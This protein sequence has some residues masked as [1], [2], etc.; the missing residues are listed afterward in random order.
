M[1]HPSAG[2]GAAPSASSKETNHPTWQ[3]LKRWFVTTETE[4]SFVKSLTFIGFL[5]TLIAAYFQYLSAYQEKVTARAKEDLAAAT[6]AF[7]E[8]ANALSIPLSLQE[9]LVFAFYDA[10]NNK[11]DVDDNAYV[12]KRAR[13]IAERYEDAYT[14]LRENINL[15]ARKVEIYLDWPS[16]LGRDPAQNN[17]LIL[18]PINSSLLGAYNF[19]CDKHLPS[20]EHGKSVLHL[21]D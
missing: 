20:F 2:S 13:A 1:S 21:Q 10:V 9:R 5:G 15:L 17:L 16:D 8:A 4:F 3:K 14:A 18:D 12:T 7:T 11:I 19:D 6:S